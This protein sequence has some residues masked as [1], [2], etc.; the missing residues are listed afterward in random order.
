ML[1][2]SLNWSGDGTRMAFTRADGGLY[3][4]T[5]EGAD[6]LQLAP[7]GILPI[8]SD[9]GERV[10]FL[11]A[12][13]A[14][15]LCCWSIFVAESDGSAVA[16]VTSDVTVVHYDFAANG[17]LLVYEDDPATTRNLIVVRPDGTG[18]RVIAPP[19]GV[20]CP[21]LPSLSP[22]GTKVAYFAFPEAQDDNGP[23]YEIY[24]SPTDRSG[25]AV[26]VSNN[27]GD[28]WWPVWS[29]DGTRIAFVSTDSDRPFGPGS[30]HAVNAD[31]TGQ[32][33]LTPTD[34]ASEPVWSPDGSRI[35]YTGVSGDQAHVFVANADGSG[36]VDV[37]PDADSSR[38]IWTG[39]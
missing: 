13:S 3:A 11:V 27:P 20:C 25:V 12:D 22:D 32:I 33:M 28:D 30:L 1:L 15:Q 4:T 39:R 36:R 2:P 17:S 31:G 34:Y 8:W 38:P 35:A 29:P 19:P 37:T 6:V 23:G 7:S 5:G 26:D 24:V 9:D 10:A 16:R 14:P 21:Q 18:R